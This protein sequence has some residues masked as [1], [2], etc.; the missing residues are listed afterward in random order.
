M[1]GFFRPALMIVGFVFSIAILNPLVLFIN[2]GFSLAVKATQADSM[3]GL[4][5]LAG[6]MIGYC[7]IML[8][9]FMMVFSLPQTFPDRIL[10]WVG[11]GIGDMGEQNSA[12]KLEGA[13]SGQARTA[14]TGMAAHHAANVK[15]SLDE[16]QKEKE[17]KQQQLRLNLK[18][19]HRRA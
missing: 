7:F 12:A 1:S 5:S 14:A 10:K 13:A 2:E 15:K 18:R 11:A 8:S 19:Q 16:K 3:T 9:V 17:K 6:F 4:F